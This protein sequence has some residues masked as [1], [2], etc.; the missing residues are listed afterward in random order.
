MTPRG[1]DSVCNTDRD[2]Y[3]SSRGHTQLTG[4][5]PKALVF[6]SPLKS[7]PDRKTKIVVDNGIYSNASTKVGTASAGGGN[8]GSS[9]A[10]GLSNCLFKCE[11]NE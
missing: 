11:V 3:E 2:G 10:F 1:D 9:S 5:K 4:L 8:N 7:P 6:A